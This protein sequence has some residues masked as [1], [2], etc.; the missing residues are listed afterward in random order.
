MWAGVSTLSVVLFVFYLS[1]Q[2]ARALAEDIPW[3]LTLVLSVLVVAAGLGV[4]TLVRNAVYPQPWV[5][6]DTDQLRA[7]RHEPIPL[8]AVDRAL[9]PVDPATRSDVL[10]LRLTGRGARVEIVLRDRRGPS[11]GPD[12]THALAEAVRRTAVAIPTTSYDPTG[13]FARYNF[14]GHVDRDSAVALVESPPAP[15]QPLPASW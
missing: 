6:L 14:P 13:R 8:S 7:G 15:G 3:P 1:G 11:L 12:D 10:V 5:N 2:A 4:V 9:I